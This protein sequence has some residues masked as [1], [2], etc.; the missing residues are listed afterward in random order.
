MCLV[1]VARKIA[2]AWANWPHVR[3]VVHHQ[4]HAGLFSWRTVCD[5]GVSCKVCHIACDEKVV[6]TM[7][8]EGCLEFG[9]AF[10]S[11]EVH[12]NVAGVWL[13]FRAVYG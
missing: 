5:V 12:A 2:E 4:R 6:E 3:L 1:I 7:R 9:Q 13:Y 11:H 10:D 8:R